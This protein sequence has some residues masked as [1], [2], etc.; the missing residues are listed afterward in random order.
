MDRRKFLK[1]M[2]TAT[3]AAAVAPLIPLGTLNGAESSSRGNRTARYMIHGN[4]KLGCSGFD[5]PDDQTVINTGLF[6][7]SL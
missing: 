6:M 2:G 7:P 4:K 5:F 1:A 3:A